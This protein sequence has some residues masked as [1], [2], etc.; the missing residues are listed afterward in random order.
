ME[1]IKGQDD[2]HHVRSQRN[3][4]IYFRNHNLEVIWARK[5][6]MKVDFSLEH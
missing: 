6:G 1:G 3:S 5:Q 2:I 4:W